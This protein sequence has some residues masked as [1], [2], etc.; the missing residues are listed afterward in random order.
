MPSEDVKVDL[1]SW[2][3][4]SQRV[5]L[6][7]TSKLSATASFPEFLNTALRLA[8]SGSIRRKGTVDPSEFSNAYLLVPA[9]LQQLETKSTVTKEAGTHSEEVPIPFHK[10]LDVP[11]DNL[12]FLGFLKKFALHLFVSTASTLNSNTT[13]PILFLNRSTLSLL[14]LKKVFGETFVATLT[15]EQENTSGF[16]KGDLELNGIRPILDQELIKSESIQ[17]I[18]RMPAYPVNTGYLKS[19]GHREG[20]PNP[21]LVFMDAFYRDHVRKAPEGCFEPSDD[22]DKDDGQSDAFIETITVSAYRTQVQGRQLV[23]NN[24]PST[25]C[26]T[27]LAQSLLAEIF[28]AIEG[29]RTP[30]ELLFFHT[31]QQTTKITFILNVEGEAAYSHNTPLP[32]SLVFLKDTFQAMIPIVSCEV[33]SNTSQTDRLRLLLYTRSI[34][35][36]MREHRLAFKNGE[37]L[38]IGIYIDKN[39]VVSVYIL[40]IKSG[41]KDVEVYQ[42]DFHLVGKIQPDKSIAGPSEILPFVKRLW[43]LRK[44][45]K[46][47]YK[48]QLDEIFDM[49]SRTEAFSTLLKK[50]IPGVQ[51]ASARMRESKPQSGLSFPAAQFGWESIMEEDEGEDKKHADE[52]GDDDSKEELYQP[53]RNVEMTARNLPHRTSIN[54]S[55]KKK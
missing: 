32:D 18:L 37:T 31:Q 17:K 15:I 54:R 7:T 4:L 6:Y 22:P 2:N 55:G 19:T 38:N 49:A 36:C 25:T 11:E 42:Q 47:G 51:S 39:L 13:I 48:N 20:T 16:K 43:D 45:L 29:E 50:K 30:G 5:T 33:E 52:D 26:R 3:R 34:L 27:S 14:V 8:T 44:A 53:T 12:P 23:L 41:S 40:S 21:R 9:S 24:H 10:L 1:Y 28:T 46:E 35:L